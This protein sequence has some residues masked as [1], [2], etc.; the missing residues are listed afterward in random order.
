MSKTGT[1]VRATVRAVVIFTALTAAAVVLVTVGAYW[2]HDGAAALGY[3]GGGMFGSALTYILL[4]LPPSR[5]S[6][7]GMSSAPADR[8]LA[9]S[10]PRP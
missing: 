9:P 8:S 5:S 3:L 6:F 4:T 1:S 2:R 7:V 10:E